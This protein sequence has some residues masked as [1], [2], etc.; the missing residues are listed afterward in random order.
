MSVRRQNY[1]NFIFSRLS[2]HSKISLMLRAYALPMR[3]LRKTRTSK[4]IVSSSIAPFSILIGG[5]DQAHRMTIVCCVN[6]VKCDGH[7]LCFIKKSVFHFHKRY[8]LQPCSPWAETLKTGLKIEN[9][10]LPV[11]RIDFF[12]DWYGRSIQLYIHVHVHVHM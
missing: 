1:R 8:I 10:P 3:V 7:Q 2:L 9:R 12:W 4:S 11:E 5:N 6:F